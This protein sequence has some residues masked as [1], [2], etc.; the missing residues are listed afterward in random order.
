MFICVSPKKKKKTS[1]H[2]SLFLQLLPSERIIKKKI[3]KFFFQL[4]KVVYFTFL[5]MDERAESLCTLKSRAFITEFN[6]RILSLIFFF[7]ACRL[8]EKIKQNNFSISNSVNFFN[9]NKT[10]KSGRLFCIDIYF[11]F[12][13]TES[14]ARDVYINTF[15]GKFQCLVSYFIFYFLTIY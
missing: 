12:S 4:C 2:F 1:E 6:T 11:I 9:N 13:P 7:F 3:Q 15:N 14:S 10:T 5:Q 8:E